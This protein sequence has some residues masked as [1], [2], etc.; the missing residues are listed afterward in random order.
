MTCI[1]L[2]GAAI[3]QTLN[4]GA[5]KTFEEYAQQICALHRVIYQTM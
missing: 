1:V 5:S 4:P 3:V 2:D